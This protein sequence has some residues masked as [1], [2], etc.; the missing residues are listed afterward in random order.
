L[1]RFQPDAKISDQAERLARDIGFSF[2]C[3]FINDKEETFYT[4]AAGFNV[5]KPFSVV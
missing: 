4:L 5:T 2:F 1:G 3:L